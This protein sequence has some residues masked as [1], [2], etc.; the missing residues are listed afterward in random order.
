M[1]NILLLFCVFVIYAC[2]NVPATK[3][4]V[5]KNEIIIP[6]SIKR[7][8][9]K[10]DSLIHG[11]T[12]DSKVFN[13]CDPNCVWQY[14]HPFRD[15][16]YVFAVQNC[17]EEFFEKGK[18]ARIYF[19]IDRGQ[20]D[21]IIWAEHVFIKIQ[22]DFMEYKDFNGDGTMDILIFSETGGRGGNAFY[23]L[24][25]VDAKNKKINCVQGFEDIVNPEYNKKHNVIIA[26]GLSGTNNYSIYK[27]SNANKVYKIGESFED[28]FDSDE[29]LLDRKITQALK[30]NEE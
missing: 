11:N 2:N 29:D 16:S 5:V 15:T 27:I 7:A 17:C 9:I 30:V 1:K 3:Q 8:F 24:Y 26:Y 28:D 23:Y 6:K 12:S 13:Q 19:G 10:P 21:K 20:T 4:N 25:L 22:N 14:Y 18:T